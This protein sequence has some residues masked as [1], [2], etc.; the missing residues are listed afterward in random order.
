MSEGDMMVFAGNAH[1]QLVQ[2]IINYLELPLGKAVVGRFSDGEV[3]VEILQNVRGRD[4]FIV[5]PTCTPTNENVME[6]SSK[7]CKW[8]VCKKKCK[9]GAKWH[10]IIMLDNRNAET[11]VF[12]STALRMSFQAFR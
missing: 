7:V 10:G 12:L 1:P 9:S 6:S 8:H 3:M 2:S 11:D 5:Q 4:V